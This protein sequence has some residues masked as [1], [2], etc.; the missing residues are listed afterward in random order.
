[1]ARG[2]SGAVMRAF[3][4]Q[5]HLITVLESERRAS[6]CVRVRFHSDTL[7]DEVSDGPTSWIRVWFPDGSGKEFQRAYTFSEVDAATGR[8]AL[9]FV[10]HEP[11][12]PASNW[13]RA[14]EP[15]DTVAVNY[16]SSVPL[17]IPDDPPA[18]YLLLGDSASIPAINTI[19]AAMPPEIP[20]EAYL[21]EHEPADRELP[22]SHHPRLRVHWVHR[23]GPQSLADA[24]EA[25]DW[26]NWYAWAGPEQ[27]SLKLIRARLKEFGFPVRRHTHSPTGHRARRWARNGRPR[28]PRPRRRSTAP[29]PVPTVPRPP[30][31]PRKPHPHR[32]PPP[33]PFRHRRPPAG[34]RPPRREDFW[35]HSSAR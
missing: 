31:R 35:R 34:G 32:C 19:I 17:E 8:F 16:M 2:F 5:D 29:F 10:L 28:T 27:G 20:I 33:S 4:A 9:D 21:E 15:G 30:P 6:H 23:A 7:F 14:A 25:R 3:G 11:S 22:V 24:I 13:A 12:G 26:S 18:G 1:M